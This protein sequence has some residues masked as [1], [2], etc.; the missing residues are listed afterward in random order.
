MIDVN[1][2][3]AIDLH[4]ERTSATCHGLADIAD[5]D[6]T[7]RTLTQRPAGDLFPPARFHFSVHPGLAARKGQN[8]TQDRIRDGKG[9]SVRGATESDP[10]TGTGLGVDR[11]DSRPPL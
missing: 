11:I 9:K 2:V 1:N 4:S 3:R 5:P 8:V 10:I 6:H 7:K